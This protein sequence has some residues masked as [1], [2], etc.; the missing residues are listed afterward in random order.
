MK[1]VEHIKAT[2]KP[3]SGLCCSNCERFGLIFFLRF[4]MKVIVRRRSRGMHDFSEN[5]LVFLVGK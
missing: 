4:L 5:A 2:A 3:N 1:A